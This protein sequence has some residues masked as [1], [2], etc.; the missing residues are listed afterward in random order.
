VGAYISQRHF[1]ESSMEEAAKR[2]GGIDIVINNGKITTRPINI[3]DSC[4]KTK[5]N[6]R[7]T[8]YS[9]MEEYEF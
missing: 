6:L 2:F 9:V 5:S 1:G 7:Q 3:S 8:P 4:V